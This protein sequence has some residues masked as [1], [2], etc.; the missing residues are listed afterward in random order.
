[1]LNTRSYDRTFTLFNI[2]LIFY[3][4]VAETY[5]SEVKELSDVKRMDIS[6]LSGQTLK[7]KISNVESATKFYVQLPS[8]SKCESIVHQYMADKDTKVLFSTKC[9]STANHILSY[10]VHKLNKKL[11]K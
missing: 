9:I 6:L 2:I 4:L 10:I 3:I 8:A 1:M 7:M 11:G 5:D